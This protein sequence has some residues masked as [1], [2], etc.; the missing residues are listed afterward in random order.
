[1]ISGVCAAVLSPRN[2]DDT[3]DVAALRI[4]LGFL[5]SKGIRA[6]A[7]NGATGEYCLNNPTT[8]RT[9][10]KEVRLVAGNDAQILCGIGAASE[11]AAVSLAT[12]AEEEE[13]TGL[14]LP[15]PFFFPYSQDDV[16]LFCSS[17]ARSTSM[18]II[19]YNLPQFTTRITSETALSLL[20]IH[21]NVVG[22]KDS[23][24]SLEN[25]RS[26]T[27]SFPSAA[28]IV[29]N[30]GALALAMSEGVCDAVISGVACAYPELILSIF[31]AGKE[32]R[33]HDLQRLDDQL[34]QLITHLDVFPTPWGLKWLLQAR[35]VIPATFSQ[36]LTEKRL[37][38]AAELMSWFSQHIHLSTECTSSREE[39]HPIDLSIR[40]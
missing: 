39:S 22:M 2:G 6:F 40:S 36:P 13:V 17:V 37:A 1:M 23:S 21:P 32:G 33:G 15:P 7:V 24:G 4:L 9:L 29:G 30:D 10:I 19:L 11:H 34:R 18:P 3:I 14:L 26:L 12:V 5:I 25:L 27:S 35:N 31:H 8:L 16:A 20:S 38:E 28:R